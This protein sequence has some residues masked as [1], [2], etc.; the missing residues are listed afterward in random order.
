[1]SAS[2]N[3]IPAGY[4]SVT[5][6]LTVKDAAKA[7]EFYEKA[8]NAVINYKMADPRT[9]GTAHAEFQIGNSTLMIS[10][11]YPDL[12][13]SAPEVGKGGSFMIYVPDIEAAFEQAV[14]AGAAEV[15]QPEDQFWGDRTARVNDPFG[16][17]WT[18]AQKIRDV[19]EEEMARLAADWQG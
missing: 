15:Q 17:R 9:G 14:G 13:F 3:H 10:D 5:P 12:G 4:Q 11:E 1:M 7:L 19:P 16:Y 6:S 8:L 2:L 18:L